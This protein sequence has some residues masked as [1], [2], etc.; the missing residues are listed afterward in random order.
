MAL[1]IRNIDEVTRAALDEYKERFDIKTDSKALTQAA[2]RWRRMDREYDSLSEELQKVENELKDY[3]RIMAG[4]EM[5]LAPA[6][7]S[8][9]QNELQF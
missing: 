3:K 7:E 6:L 2:C 8:I 1:T 4:L 9:R 5:Y